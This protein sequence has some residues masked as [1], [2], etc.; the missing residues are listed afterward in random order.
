[1]LEECH[2]LPFPNPPIRIPMFHTST[3]VPLF[4]YTNWTLPEIESYLKVKPH[5]RRDLEEII[6]R[7]RQE[8]EADILPR[9]L[10]EAEVGF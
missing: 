5:M 1:M 10:T 8:Y 9:D 2:S 3:T 7:G 6:P 4:L